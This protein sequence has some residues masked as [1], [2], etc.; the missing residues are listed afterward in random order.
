MRKIFFCCLI[1]SVMHV[2]IAMEI[3]ESIKGLDWAVE[4]GDYALFD[5]EIKRIEN[6][7]P[8]VDA[9]L[10]YKKILEKMPSGALWFWLES[11]GLGSVGF[12]GLNTWMNRK[13]CSSD[14]LMNAGAIAFFVLL[15]TVSAD[16]LRRSCNDDCELYAKM[17]R[18]MARSNKNIFYCVKVD[19]Y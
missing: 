19:A 15:A 7:G 16:K 9:T 2:S 17:V 11:L 6:T 12:L 4:I 14:E 5:R 10:I 8:R 3:P 18:R 13:K 1:L